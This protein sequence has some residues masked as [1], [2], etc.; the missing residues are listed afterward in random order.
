MQPV[1]DPVLPRLLGGLSATLRRAEDG[2]GVL[3]V[4]TIGADLALAMTWPNAIVVARE[5]MAKHELDP[6]TL[7]AFEAVAQYGLALSGFPRAVLV[8]GTALLLLERSAAPR[9]L[10]IDGPGLGGR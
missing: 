5:G 6:A 1:T 10:A 2:F 4:A 3:T 9:W 7:V 8:G